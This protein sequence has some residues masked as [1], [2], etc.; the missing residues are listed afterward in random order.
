MIYYH[1]ILYL[2]RFL[3]AL[4]KLDQEYKSYITYEKL[5]SITEADA[6]I[7]KFDILVET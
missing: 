1:G 6:G 4:Y 5:Y 2:A 7:G 3:Y